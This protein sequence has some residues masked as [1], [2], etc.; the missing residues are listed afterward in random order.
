M[1]KV[2]H[3]SKKMVFWAFFV[4]LFF[5]T[6]VTVILHLYED[7][8]KQYAIDELN[9]YLTT[10]VQVRNIELSIFHDFPNASLEFDHVFIADAYKHND[11]KDTLLYADQL[12]FHFNLLDIWRGN[13]N[14]KRGSIH[15]GKIN[16]KTTQS[17]DVNYGIVK[18]SADTVGA[19][20]FSF[21]F[22]LLKVD[23][24]AFN[25]VNASTRQV[26]NLFIHDAL[27]SGDFSASQYD[28]AAAG[29]L[30]INKLKSGSLTL[31]A[32]K[33]AE[34][35]IGMN[36][37]TDTKMYRLSHGNLNVEKMI[38]D[39]TGFIDSNSIDLAV[40]GKEI[41]IA[42]LA[43]SLTAQNSAAVNYS[44]EGLFNFDA[45]IK[46]Q[47]GRTIMPSIE[48]DFEVMNG[49]I[50][51]PNNQLKIHTI[52][53]AGSYQNKQKNREEQ[54][55]FD[56][57]SFKLLN[58]HFKGSGQMKNFA[59]P[60][61]RTKAVGDLDLLAFNDFFQ[62]E[63]VDELS[64]NVKLDLSCVIQF[65]DPEYRKDKFAFTESYGSIELSKVVFKA[66]DRKL[67]FTDIS[68]NVLVKGKDAATKNLVINTAN[69]NLVLNGAMKNLIP[70]LEGTGSLGLIAS[71][72]SSKIDLN[73]FLNAS[74]EEENETTTKK[75]FELPHNLNA[76]LELNLKSFNW[77]N[78]VFKNIRG[79]FLLANRKATISKF[80]LN[81]LGGTV[82]GSL[83]LNNL[84]AQGNSVDGDLD[85]SKIDVKSLFKEWD[86]FNQTSITDQHLSGTVGGS[87]NLLLLFD[88][89]FDLIEEKIFAL[90]TIKIKNGALINME[91]M[92]AV[93][94]Y[95]RSNK[96]L[97][98]MLNKHIDQ[99]EEKLM[100]LKF[101]ELSNQIE[102]KN[103]RITIPKM[104]IH[105]NALDVSLFGWHDFDNAIEYH[106]S[107]RFRQLKSKP[108]YTE[109]GKI[110][111]DGLGIIIYMTMSGS[112]DNPVFTLDKDE[113]K[114][115]LKENLNQEKSTIKSMLKTEFGLFQKDTTIKEQVI[116]NKKEVEFIYYEKDIEE[117]DTTKEKV[118]NKK[119]VGKFFDKLKQEAE[120][121]KKQID[122]EDDDIE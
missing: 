55:D 114:N 42:D 81:T 6:V 113:L 100:Q 38:F 13:Y 104:M 8:I 23:R 115:E 105:T 60:I 107:F 56:S 31:I 46:G 32:D 80:K 79:Q 75:Q 21:L 51:E 71:L 29:K 17:G 45:L 94:D 18:P 50:I 16:L 9:E 108:T 14:V 82:T 110:E 121:D 85:F 33:E 39:V 34:L 12:F 41:R 27:L 91:T 89:Y 35:D 90:S 69:S 106:F 59:Q 84:L 92:K 112:V 93:T 19:N 2:W 37:N 62:F 7:E 47:L 20:N 44:G 36:I 15:G 120:N 86:N 61:F 72:E 11:S 4:G 10:D 70:Y 119:R 65:F 101:S 78:H 111:D 48:A 26:Y 43:N 54:L 66:S 117:S 52:N 122:F 30:H 22:E 102:I 63:N 57:F 83:T 28:L 53:V 96:A 98:L 68:G 49:T 5:T 118:K 97:K 64:G 3:F 95:M 103:R 77:D 99:F 88:T 73:E 116:D 87:V 25:Y 40:V 1:K 74:A 24:V 58:S 76:N 67:R 109:F